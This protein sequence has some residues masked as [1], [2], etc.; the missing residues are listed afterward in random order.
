[1]IT[2]KTKINLIIGNPVSHS[3]SPKLHNNLYKILGI[4]DEFVFLASQVASDK[5]FESISSIKALGINGF[6]VTIPHKTSVIEYLDDVDSTAMIIGSVNTIINRGGVLTGYNTD[7]LGTIIPIAN[8]KNLIIKNINHIPRFLE[9]QKVALIGA[10]G[11]ARA[12]AFAV[13]QAGA[14]LY[15]FN[16][17]IEKAI[18]L[19]DSLKEMLPLSRIKVFEIT[20]LNNVMDCDIVINS[21]SIGMTPDTDQSPVPIEYL[22][23]C[24]TVFDAVYTPMETKLL[25]DAKSKCCKTISGLEMFIYQAIYQF[26][27]HTGIRPTREQVIECLR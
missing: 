2:S 23:S 19:A 11:V 6:S 4:D 27:L 3:L 5:L 22:K 16:R 7:W 9:S 8:S 13:L 17:T 18:I 24:Q 25:Q 10:G 12:I 14:E 1:M 20:H 21:T 15:I 26:E